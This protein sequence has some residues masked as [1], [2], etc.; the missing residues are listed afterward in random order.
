MPREHSAVPGRGQRGR[1]PH[2]SQ[3]ARTT[4]KLL[5]LAGLVAKKLCRVAA[6]LRARK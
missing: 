3:A 1:S 4:R 5:Q 6:E 2:L